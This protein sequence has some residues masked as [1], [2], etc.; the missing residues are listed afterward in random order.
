M[1]T[2]TDT[3][4]EQKLHTRCL[5]AHFGVG[6]KWPP[7]FFK[8]C[9]QKL[10]AMETTKAAIVADPRFDVE[11][12]VLPFGTATRSK[13]LYMAGLADDA[14]IHVAAPLSFNGGVGVAR[15]NSSIFSATHLLFDRWVL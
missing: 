1:H 10:D 9:I 2:F 13:V 8:A 11:R 5:V 14:K 12:I 6:R 3:K 4:F 7:R 15:G